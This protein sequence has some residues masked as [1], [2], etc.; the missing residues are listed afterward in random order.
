MKK[1]LLAILGIV[2]ISAIFNG[3][4][5]VRMSRQIDDV[6]TTFTVLS[7]RQSLG[8]IKVFRYTNWREMTDEQPNIMASGKRVYSGA[9]AVSRDFILS[10]NLDF[11]DC[12]EIDGS[13]Y[14]IEDV[15]N[16][17]HKRAVDIYVDTSQMK[18][19]EAK[20]YL[21]R[22]YKSRLWVIY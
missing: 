2:F 15:M 16:K 4:T 3:V 9:I 10:G 11:G 8:W 18:K 5:Y 6:K 12:V 20:K 22:S 13:R 7:R 19:S 21:N 1:T 14:I 17:R